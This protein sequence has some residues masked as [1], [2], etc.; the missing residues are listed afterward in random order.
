LEAAAR[1]WIVGG[2]VPWKEFYG[3][4]SPRRVSLPAY[5]F[6]TKAYWLD[7]EVVSSR[8]IDS[9]KSIREQ[10][11]EGL[12]LRVAEELKLSASAI[13]CR[14][15]FMEFG[16]DSL[17]SLRLAQGLG[18]SFGVSIRLRDLMQYPSIENLSEF[19]ASRMAGQGGTKE[20]FLVQQ[21]AANASSGDPLSECQKGLWALQKMHPEV[22]AYN[23][24]LSLKV[25]RKL[26]VE[27]LREACQF[28]NKQYP[29]L[30]CGIKEKNGS[31]FQIPTESPFLLEETSFENASGDTIEGHLRQRLKEPFDLETGPLVRFHL[32]HSSQAESILL[33]AMHHLVVDG[34]SAIPLL[35]TLLDAYLAISKGLKPEP[36]AGSRSFSDFVEWERMQLSG[37]SGKILESYWRKQM[38]GDLPALNLIT[39]RPRSS[40]ILSEGEIVTVS[41]GKEF[42]SELRSFVRNQRVSLATLFLGL[43]KTLL[44][45]YSGDS[46]IIVGV[47]TQVRPEGFECHVGYFI[48]MLPIRTRGLAELTFKD[49]LQSL[50]ETMADGV[51][52]AAYP[53]PRM[54]RV[55]GLTGS[56]SLN[57]LFQ[58]AFEYQSFLAADDFESRYEENF[59]LKLLDSP[60]Q[61]GEYELVLEVVERG[62]EFDL[63]FKY[64][65]ALFT[66][67]AIQRMAKHFVALARNVVVDP[68]SFLPAYGMLSEVELGQIRGEWNNTKK[69][70]PRDQ[71]VYDLIEARALETPQAIALQFAD[72][73]MTYG[74]LDRRSSVF[75]SYL[76]GL[77]VKADDL[78][79]ICMQRSL[80]MMVGL[81]GILKAGG[82]YVP[83]DPTYPAERLT[84]MLKDSHAAVIVTQTHLRE[85]VAVWVADSRNGSQR[86]IVEVDGHWPEIEQVAGSRGSLE[87]RNTPQNLA[88]VIYTSGSTGN[89]KGVMIPH[90]AL[91]NF[92]T[93]MAHEPGLRREDRFLAVTTLSFDIA[94]LE[95][96]LPLVQGAQCYLCA[97]DQTNDATRL[98][99]VIHQSRPTVMQATPSTW[100][101]LL[102]GGWR[103]EERVKILCGGEALPEDLARSFTDGRMDAWNM[104][105]PTETTIWSTLQRIE[106]N[107][108]IGI[109]RPIANTRVYILD[110]FGNPAPVGVSGELLIAGDGLASGY[111]NRPELTAERFIELPELPGERLYKTGDL[112]C[113]RDDGTIKY[114]ERVDHQ[115]KIRGHRIELEEIE[116]QLNRLP[117]VEKA[118]VVVR[119]HPGL[120]QLICY[121]VPSRDA[122]VRVSNL[123]RV[124]APQLKAHLPDYMLPAFFIPLG[125]L[126]LTPNG[127]IDRK[128]LAARKIEVQKPAER[129]PNGSDLENRVLQI[130][131]EV[132]GV[133][134]L[135]AADAFFE[136]GGDSVLAVILAQ[137]ISSFS[138]VPFKATD[139]FR[140]STVRAIGSELAS[141]KRLDLF[142]SRPGM[143]PL[144]ASPRG[145]EASGAGPDYL[146]DSLAIIGISCQF[147]SAETHQAFWANLRA[148]VESG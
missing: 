147:P 109:G 73:S 63:N 5:P 10:I 53:F 38:S 32:V 61:T 46:E 141:Q 40:T 68:I 36:E 74:E 80:D 51:D 44:H 30:S 49:L 16:L 127:K 64:H 54:V 19:L 4:R 56:E 41:I 95:L 110:R 59:P 76:Q 81:L 131:R 123:E 11:Q 93:S 13:D 35:Q 7:D 84:F 60:R 15:H 62:G 133:E 139:L 117:V 72:R 128:N 134:N 24:P 6:E 98:R 3:G 96:F 107:V 43:Y 116:S 37:E 25:F 20:L 136:A 75:A 144:E 115:V 113:W 146:K 28:L 8:V 120:K 99:A 48:N 77:G 27:I 47:P 85:R 97:A 92:L 121:Y 114:L 112:V 66:N 94:G 22:T 111:L 102:H 57:P 129:S 108:P 14:K 118:V 130:W 71:C 42:A 23:V 143:R 67:A 91:T 90:R 31:L 89:P 106:A 2:T 138:G 34:V 142:D 69:E 135:G 122:A 83:L 39:D 104:Y 140:L 87:R 132:L 33:I 18:R 29:L 58:V 119:E 17:A 124:L 52:H 9:A 148:G 82:A 86:T 26:D 1:L 65:A 101:M 45:R 79:A 105:G 70:Y 145:G 137:R 50:R 21:T 55:L 12:T 103:N 125:E 78:V 126:P 88:Y 100:R